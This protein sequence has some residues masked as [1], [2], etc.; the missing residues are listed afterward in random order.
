[1]AKTNKNI[2]RPFVQGECIYLRE[3]RVSDVNENYYSWMND[4]EVNQYLETRFFP[5]SHEK[6][7]NY[8]RETG[9]DIN[10][11][12]MAIITKEENRHIGNIKIGP[13]NWFH[14]FAD[15]SLIIGEKRFW[16]SGYGAEAI[17]LVV[18]YAFQ[19]LNLNRLQA[20]I[21]AANTGSIKAFSK[22]GFSEEGKLRKKRFLDGKYIDEILFG[23]I[24][25]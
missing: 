9:K 6:I 16:G 20:G 15:V 25:E 24:N 21:A 4:P 17:Q 10:S 23:I 11:V 2:F 18:H 19:K 1:M 12:F 7:E 13:I 8:V 14:R 22:A 3:V 5:Y